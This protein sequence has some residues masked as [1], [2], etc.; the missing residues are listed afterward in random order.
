[1]QAD[2]QPFVQE[3]AVTAIGL[4]GSSPTGL[5]MLRT[6]NP[7]P[8]NVLLYVYTHRGLQSS[9]IRSA[10]QTALTLILT[11]AADPQLADALFIDMCN[12]YKSVASTWPTY[13][14]SGVRAATRVTYSMSSSGLI[15]LYY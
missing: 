5:S 14:S 1:M 13:S 8:W 9:D 12:I 2:S 11:N 6:Y 3:A 10:C 15:E 7:P 4:I